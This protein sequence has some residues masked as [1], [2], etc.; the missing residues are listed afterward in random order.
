MV[1]VRLHARH[2]R[3]HVARGVLGL[4][5]TFNPAGTFAKPA[6]SHLNPPI[7]TPLKLDTPPQE[8]T[9]STQT[10][11][12][13]DE[14]GTDKLPLV[15]RALPSAQTKEEAQ[16]N[17]DK[18]FRDSLSEW[19]MVAFSGVSTIIFFLQLCVFG[20]QAQLLRRTVERMGEI[21][22]AQAID[23]K[24]SIA[25]SEK[26]ANAQVDAARATERAIVN[27]DRPYIMLDRIQHQLQFASGMETIAG[28]IVGS[29]LNL[30]VAN[31]GKTPG[32]IKSVCVEA[33]I[34]PEA[35]TETYII[36]YAGS[37]G[38]IVIVPD[39]RSN[40]ELLGFDL[41]NVTNDM[42]KEILAYKSILN[43]CINITYV[44]MFDNIHVGGAIVWWVPYLNGLI[45]NQT[46][47][48][49]QTLK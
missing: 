44:D 25:E 5:L 4:G 33:S 24:R 20:R 39:Q 12:N 19:G 3:A 31:Y 41:V 17:A 23:M 38:N 22:D 46:K 32:V 47:A 27:V 2:W 13:T 7:P 1:P 34:A 29:A 49:I 11:P 10:K 45:T 9:N 42:W 16:R 14:R 30:V 6:S 40:P 48:D 26:A 8:Q 15:I 35:R 37:V 36:S 43:I 28:G 18:E 21:A